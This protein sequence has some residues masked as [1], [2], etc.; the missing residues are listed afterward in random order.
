MLSIWPAVK[1]NWLLALP[2]TAPFQRPPVAAVAGLFA[3]RWRLRR[4]MQSEVRRAGPIDAM[5]LCAPTLLHEGQSWNTGMV[6]LI[7]YL[8]TPLLH[9]SQRT[10][11]FMPCRF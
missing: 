2:S 10:H 3:Y 1:W 9:I 7:S 6:G 4:E 5:H 8:V 11:T